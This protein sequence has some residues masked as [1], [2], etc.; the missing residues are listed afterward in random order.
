MVP[1]CKCLWLSQRFLVS[2]F[3]NASYFLNIHGRSGHVVQIIFPARVSKFIYKTFCL[4]DTNDLMYTLILGFVNFGFTVRTCLAIAFNLTC[5]L[6]VIK[7]ILEFLP[8]LHIFPPARKI[9]IFCHLLP[10]WYRQMSSLVGTL[11]SPSITVVLEWTG[12]RA[13]STVREKY[14]LLVEVLIE[15]VDHAFISR[16]PWE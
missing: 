8:F 3:A 10:M 6:Q 14:H 15:L 5:H 7:A 11:Y 13:K 2:V 12:L 9:L 1:F 16:F 4:H